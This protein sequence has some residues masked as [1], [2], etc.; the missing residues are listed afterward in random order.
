MIGIVVPA[1]NEEACVR[2]CLQALAA[3]ARHPDLG[4][5]SVEIVVVLDACTDAT[6]VYACAA[7]A[8]TLSIRARNVGMARAAGAQA[9]LARGARWLSFTDAD[10]VVS[11]SW[12]V[13]QLA[14][15]ADAVCGT[16]GVVDWTPHGCHATLLAWHF[17]QTY[18]D[19]DGHSHI[20]GANL[21]VSAAAY[22]LAGGFRHLAC[23]E[24]VALVDALIASGASVAW[25]AKPRVVTSARKNAK[26]SGGFA[27]ALCHAVVQ[28]LEAVSQ[29]R[30]SPLPSLLNP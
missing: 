20:H 21:G 17:Q 6:G 13:E 18:Q 2:S 30:F 16:V 14:L 29:P 8:T 11:P 10:T 25:S 12:L 5:E 15:R 7:G 27:D 28:R 26:A 19:A 22:R 4:G 23:S 9:L 24:D 1:H 3:A